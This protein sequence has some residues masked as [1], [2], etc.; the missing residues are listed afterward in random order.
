MTYRFYRQIK[1]V[2]RFFVTL[3]FPDLD[4]RGALALV[5]ALDALPG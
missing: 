1:L 2:A 3:A 5:A 4:E